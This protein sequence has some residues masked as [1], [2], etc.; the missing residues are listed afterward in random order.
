MI[1]LSGTGPVSAAGTTSSPAP[2][3]WAPRRGRS[4]WVEAG[5]PLDPAVVG[6]NHDPSGTWD[7]M[8]DYAMM[9]RNVRAFMA[10]FHCSQAGRLQGPRVLCRRWHRHGAVLGPARDRRRRR[11]DRLPAGARVGVADDL[12]VGPSRG[13]PARQAPAVHRGFAVRRP[14]RSSGA[15]RSRLLPPSGSR[16]APR[17]CSSGSHGCPSTS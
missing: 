5:S 8:V 10:L 12:P 6:A 4:P 16:S 2:S 9:S 3:R 1:L 15:W 17:S 7:P 14:R 13:R 11:Q